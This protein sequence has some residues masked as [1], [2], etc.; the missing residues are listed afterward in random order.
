V[1]LIVFNWSLTCRL[2][3]CLSVS[4][5]ARLVSTWSVGWVFFI[6]SIQEFVD[7]RSLAG[8]CGHFSSKNRGPSDE[9]QD[10]KWRF[11]LNRLSNVD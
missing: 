6:F 5:D 1:S 2:S 3:V 4:M 9:P 7:P 8:E 10:T 11:T